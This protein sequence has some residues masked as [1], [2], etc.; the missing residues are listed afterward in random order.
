MTKFSLAL[1]YNNNLCVNGEE[2][3]PVSFAGE[4]RGSIFISSF[5]SV[6]PSDP[7][8]Y[9]IMECHEAICLK[10]SLEKIIALVL[11]NSFG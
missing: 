5:E 4:N 1:P 8:Y 6:P 9:F 11:I 3:N 2:K 7:L 10:F